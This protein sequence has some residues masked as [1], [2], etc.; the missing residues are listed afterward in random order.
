MAEQELELQQQEQEEESAADIINELRANSVPKQKYDRIVEENRKLMRSLANGEQIEVKAPEKPDIA[1]LDKA[2]YTDD[3]QH[4]SDL[5]MISKTLE[6]RKALIDETGEDIFIP[7]G[8]RFAP[9][10]NDIAQAEKVADVF[11]Q[12]VDAA[13][14]DS[15]K[16][17]RLLDDRIMDVPLP[18]SK[19]RR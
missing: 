18:M 17:V 11:Q 4:L 2:L 6:L 1:E 3:V 13:D 10:D 7:V 12:C 14:G 19:R 15:Y 16:F 5:E 8:K 9:E